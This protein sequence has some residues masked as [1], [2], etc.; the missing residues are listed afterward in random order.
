MPLS[1]RVPFEKYKV[2]YAFVWEE[3][4]KTPSCWDVK[5]GRRLC[6]KNCSTFQHPK[7][8]MLANTTYPTCVKNVLKLLS[9]IV[10][11]LGKLCSWSLLSLTSTRN[12]SF[13]DKNPH[14]GANFYH[15]MYHNMT[16][17]SIAS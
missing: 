9:C 3:L 4:S 1:L 5:L 6:F 16:Q 12:P 14:D 15:I 13:Y 7:K 8:H 10:V 17:K 11:Y 2:N